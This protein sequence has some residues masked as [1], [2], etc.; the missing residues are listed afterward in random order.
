MGSQLGRQAGRGT[1]AVNEKQT[2]YCP[3]YEGGRA[4]F[5]AFYKYFPK[6]QK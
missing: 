2:Y 6:I 5:Y 4:P 3:Q 1:R